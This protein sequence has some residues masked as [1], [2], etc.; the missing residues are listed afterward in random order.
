MYL[1]GSV[2]Y[3]KNSAVVDSRFSQ[4]LRCP[5][6]SSSQ[7]MG[8]L[9]ALCR[10]CANLSNPSNGLVLPDGA[11]CAPIGLVQSNLPCLLPI[12]TSMAECSSLLLQAD[13]LD[14]KYSYNI[15]T[16]R[17]VFLAMAF[18]S[19]S[20]PLLSVIAMAYLTLFPL[21]TTY[22][23]GSP[24]DSH[25][26]YT[27][28]D[29]FLSAE[30]DAIGRDSVQYPGAKEALSTAYQTSEHWVEI[31]IVLIAVYGSLYSIVLSFAFCSVLVVLLSRDFRVVVSMLVTIAGILVTLLA[32]FKLFGWTLGVVEAVALSV[33]V[34]NSLDYCIH[35]TEGYMSMDARHLAFVDK[36]MVRCVCMCVCVC[37]YM[38]VCV[39]VCVCT[40]VCVCVCVYMRMQLCLCVCRC[41]YTGTCAV[42]GMYTYALHKYV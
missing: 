1:C 40:C 3:H 31:N 16:N 29:N 21:Q 15:T 39:C 30:M 4:T 41:T 36:F 22:V 34:G 19:V 33:L 9:R 6:Q 7:V 26:L 20:V 8:T 10:L 18:R 5:V 12:I 25:A 38:C 14:A 35:L 2:S 27:K 42:L 17:L 37:V 28:W 32:L 24:Y 13:A 11:E 23:S